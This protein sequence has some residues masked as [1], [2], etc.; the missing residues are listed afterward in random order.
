MGDPCPCGDPV[1][2]HP[3]VTSLM[4][5]TTN[6]DKIFAEELDKSVSVYEEFDPEDENDPRFAIKVDFAPFFGHFKGQIIKHMLFEGHKLA[7]P[8][9]NHPVLET[10]LNLRGRRLNTLFRISFLL[11]FFFV[12]AHSVYQIAVFFLR[13]EPHL[14]VNTFPDA[15]TKDGFGLECAFFLITFVCL[16]MLLVEEI[17]LIATFR[18]NYF[19]RLDAWMK[20]IM[21]TLV[22]LISGISNVL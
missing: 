21:Y 16:V 2:P 13:V 20:L 10:Y 1:K 17:L 18:S 12:L 22:R 5:H 11:Y 7:Q 19:H 8:A 4:R 9:F 15:F 6:W 3:V 14:N